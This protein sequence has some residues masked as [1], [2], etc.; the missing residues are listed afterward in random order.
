MR[1]DQIHLLANISIG[2]GAGLV[3]G[4]IIWKY[5]PLTGWVT[6]ILTGLD[7]I[8]SAYVAHHLAPYLTTRLLG[9]GK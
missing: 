7:L 1:L 6:A 3:L 9:K 8:I 4:V 2:V 5:L